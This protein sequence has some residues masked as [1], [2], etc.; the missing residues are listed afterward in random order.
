[1]PHLTVALDVARIPRVLH[2]A[3]IDYGM[4]R[5]NRRTRKA[6]RNASHDFGMNSS[7]FMRLAA[8]AYNQKV[9]GISRTD[10]TSRNA[11]VDAVWGIWTHKESER[12]N[13]P[14]SG[15]GQ[16]LYQGNLHTRDGAP[17]WEVDL[18]LG[19]GGDKDSKTEFID[20]LLH[21]HGDVINELHSWVANDRGL[22]RTAEKRLAEED[23]YAE[24]GERL[25]HAD[26]AATRMG[27]V[28]PIVYQVFMLHMGWEGPFPGIPFDRI[29]AKNES[30]LLRRRGWVGRRAYERQGYTVAKLSKLVGLPKA[31]IDQI[32]LGLTPLFAADLEL[33]EGWNINELEALIGG[34][35]RAQAAAIARKPTGWSTS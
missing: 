22:T 28:S 19:E 24:T 30:T 34:D 15:Q 5:T 14:G 7:P 3:G 17:W 6:R 25:P 13:I 31:K 4:T 8:K 12:Q 18:L 27:L 23:Y 26:A 11:Y 20:E 9:R 29:V 35:E 10:S 33:F 32:I 2:F 1:V 21:Y 16:E